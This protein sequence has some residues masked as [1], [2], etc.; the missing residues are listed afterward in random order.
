MP[1][2]VD[3]FTD[4]IDAWLA[5]DPRLRA[6]VVHERLVADYRFTGRY[7][8]IKIYCAEAGRRLELESDAQGRSPGLHRRFEVVPGAQAQVDWGDEGLLLA[9]G[10]VTSRTQAVRAPTTS[11]RRG[12]RRGWR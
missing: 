7:Q 3:P 1:R 12:G 10:G 4:L 8:R 11:V 6:T 2:L 9:A 5:D